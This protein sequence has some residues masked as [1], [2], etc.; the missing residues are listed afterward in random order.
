VRRASIALALAATLVTSCGG[1]VPDRL[2][3]KLQDDVATIRQLA[4]DGRP[5]L[6]R[7][8]LALFVDLVMARMRDG[9]VDEDRGLEILEAAEV[10]SVQ[11]A[12][13]PR[14]SPIPEESPSPSPQ[15]DEGDEGGGEGKPDKD[16]DKG[17]GNGEGH[18]NDD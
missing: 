3:T 11:L 1:D 9:R 16:E 13:L 2:A 8:E 17:K 6:A 15:V 7:G 10:V 4:E 12:L 14:P 5:G 18:G